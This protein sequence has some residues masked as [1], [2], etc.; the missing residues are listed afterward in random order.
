MRPD[1]RE[2]RI[3]TWEQLVVKGQ[4]YS[5]VVEHIAEDYDCSPRTV[6]GDIS[7]M[8]EWLPK[9]EPEISDMG[10]SRIRELRRNRQRMQQMATQAQAQG[11]P[12]VELKVRREIDRNIKDDVNIAQSLGLTRE[13]PAKHSHM[14]TSELDD[15]AE[16]M[17]DWVTRDAGGESTDVDDAMPGSERER[18]R[19]SWVDHDNGGG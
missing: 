8:D 19:E 6:E 2:R 5:D 3:A 4:R 10:V 11:D 7:K 18:E 15:D 9:L 13:E 1:L 16:A 17:L 14:L 12:D